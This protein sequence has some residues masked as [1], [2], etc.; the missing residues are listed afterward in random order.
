MICSKH[1][2]HL[3]STVENNKQTLSDVGEIIV[4][5]PSLYHKSGVSLIVMRG[6]TGRDQHNGCQ[7]WAI[8]DSEHMIVL[9]PWLRLR[10]LLYL[11]SHQYWCWESH[12]GRPRD[13]CVGGGWV[14]W[15]YWRGQ[16]RRF[17]SSIKTLKWTMTLRDPMIVR[18]KVISR[19]GSPDWNIV[20]W[21]GYFW[22]LLGMQNHR[23]IAVLISAC[24]G[25]RVESVGGGGRVPVL[26]SS[27]S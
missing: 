14:Q 22:R 15:S 3:P 18:R 20:R 8:V 5:G 10:A 7:W 13:H 25:P 2:F 9:T 16:I 6:I 17:P 4:L 23:T 12:K 27:Y 24:L 1:S 19:T 11:D 26:L 21:N